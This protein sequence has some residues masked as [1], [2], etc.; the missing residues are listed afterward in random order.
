MTALSKRLRIAIGAVL[1][2]LGIST[3]GIVEWR[4]LP[5]ATQPVNVPL[6]L[7]GPAQIAPPPFAIDRDGTYEIW[8]QVDHAVGLLNFGCLTAEP[9]FEKPCRPRQP[10]LDTDWSLSSGGLVRAAGG[11]GAAAWEQRSAAV[12]ASDAAAARRHFQA[13][14]D[15]SD[16]P[17][18]ETPFYHRLG[19]F[20][21]AAGRSYLLTLGVYR[22]APT[23]ARLHPRLIVGLTASTA[24]LGAW[25]TLFCVLCL[26]LGGFILLRTLVPRKTTP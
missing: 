15:R 1:I 9:G 17:S 2:L 26:S 8:L 10:E 14:S 6:T 16:N 5:A 20:R 25:A 3:I 22:P 23:L 13:Y 24:R 18:D 21:A 11:R 12:P 7:R 19:A 4:Y